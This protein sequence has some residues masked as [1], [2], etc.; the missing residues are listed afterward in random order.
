MGEFICKCNEEL[1]GFPSDATVQ[2]VKL[3]LQRLTGEDSI[4]AIILADP[5][6]EGIYDDTVEFDS[7]ENAESIISLARAS[8]GLRY[9]SSTFKAPYYLTA[10]KMKYDLIPKPRIFVRDLELISVHFGCKIANGKFHILW[11]LGLN[12]TR[13]YAFFCHILWSIGSTFPMRTSGKLSCIV[14]LTPL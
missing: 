10:K 11:T 3:F 2:K 1:F 4:Y 12:Y 13:K 8:E 14:S 6:N 7:T 9:D 5:T